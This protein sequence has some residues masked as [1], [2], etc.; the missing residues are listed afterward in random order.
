MIA[1]SVD[2]GSPNSV[3]FI[4]KTTKTHAGIRS[5]KNSR[6]SSILELKLDELRKELS[7]DHG[8]IF[9]H[10]ALSTQQISMISAQKPNSMEL[11]RAQP[12]EV[13]EEEETET[14]ALKRL[15]RKKHLILVESILCRWK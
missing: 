6:T 11:I 4:G 7:S 14:R 12:D 8:G 10:S 5:V 3:I 1:Y 2:F 15:K 13:K 9:Q